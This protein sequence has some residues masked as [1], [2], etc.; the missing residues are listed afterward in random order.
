MC[1]RYVTVQSMDGQNGAGHTQARNPGGHT[2]FS[3]ETS[4]AGQRVPYWVSVV[5]SGVNQYSGSS[6]WGARATTPAKRRTILTNNATIVVTLPPTAVTHTPSSV[7]TYIHRAA[8]QPA[9]CGRFLREDDLR[10]TIRG[11]RGRAGF[12]RGHGVV[13]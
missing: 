8:V 11:G 13:V 5:L 3:A 7:V 6:G 4:S 1:R 10:C 2:E 9:C 12:L